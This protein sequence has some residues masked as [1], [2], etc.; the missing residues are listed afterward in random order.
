MTEKYQY[1][2]IKIGNVDITEKIERFSY[3]HKVGSLYNTASITVGGMDTAN[4][5]GADVQIDAGNLFTGFVHSIS[6]QGKDRYAISCR[7]NGAK[8]TEP[9]SHAD[10]VLE[11][12]STASELVALYSGISGLNIIYESAELYFGG[13]YER[14]G[15]MLDALANLIAVT[16][17][18]VV[19]GPLFIHIAPAHS[20]AYDGSEVREED[21]FDFV[22][23]NRT[24]EN[25]GVGYVTVT[26]G[27]SATTDVV[28][29]NG[30]YCEINEC[31][32][33]LE[34]FANPSGLIETAKGVSLSGSISVTERLETVSV[35]DAMVI[36]LDCAI[37]SVQSVTVNGVETTDVQYQNGHKTLW[38]ASE[39][40]GVIT[41]S[42]R[43][44]VQRGQAAISSTPMGKFISFDLYYL[45][46]LLI[47]QGFL[48]ADCG[49]YDGSTSGDDSM[50]CFVPSVL[51]YPRGFDVWTIGGDPKFRFFNRSVE[52]KH[53]TISTKEQY[54]SVERASLEPDGANYRHRA[55]YPISTALSARSSGVDVAYTIDEDYFVF[56]Q[57]YPRLEVSYKT[58]ATRH[59]VQ[60]DNIE[61]GE[62]TMVIIDQNT[63]RT[64]E[65]DLQG[66]DRDSI[67][68]IECILPQDVPIDIAGETGLP[69]ADVEGRTLFVK[70]PNGVETSYTVDAHGIIRAH[71]TVN[72]DYEVDISAL[73]SGT[74][75]SDTR[76]II[77]RVNVN[78]QE[79]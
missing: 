3:S 72:G 70:D 56:S 31:D 39:K 67:D 47:F 13:S 75:H 2:N 34:V 17:A 52:I 71:V 57:Y 29:N 49:G 24:I 68:Y 1:F 51:F 5:L 48:S 27:G 33:T 15:T 7:S 66:I 58:N 61:N 26:N 4:L 19:E 10:T 35:T 77:L 16:G 55:Q 6:R 63:G 46:Q 53:P 28:S 64:C 21:I 74:S 45:D 9:Y 40:R 76:V 73:T 23:D 14:R 32:G 8:L 42:Y 50:S 20:I 54:I 22:S 43:A 12:A 37:E 78:T 69:V 41:I 36:D 11:Q 38:F 18:D 59:Y 60:F 44:Y 79:G 25:N 30:I 62:I 65:H